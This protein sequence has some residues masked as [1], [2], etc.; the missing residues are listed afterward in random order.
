MDY[1]QQ[2]DSP[3]S[4]AVVVTDEK[5]RKVLV[6]DHS[7]SQCFIIPVYTVRPDIQHADLQFNA[8]LQLQTESGISHEDGHWTFVCDV[9]LSGERSVH[10]YIAAF[11]KAP[12]A[13][14]GWHWCEFEDFRQKALL[15]RS[16]ESVVQDS[17]SLATASL[18]YLPIL[19]AL[20]YIPDLRH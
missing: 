16:A 20:G 17:M 4:V 9:Q 14:S 7:D 19:Q 11:L 1:Q 13:P 3:N 10:L 15:S 18:M 12:E 6:K 2:Q 8:R 5:G